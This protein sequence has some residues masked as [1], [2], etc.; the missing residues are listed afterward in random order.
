MRAVVVLFPLVPVTAITGGFR[1]HE[2]SSISLTMGISFSL[3]AAR[4]GMAGSTPGLRTITS[5]LRKVWEVCFPSSISIPRARIHPSVA[6]Q[7]PPGRKPWTRLTPS[8][9]APSI[10]AR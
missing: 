8:A 3:A 5:P 10:S 9:S 4:G 6:K 7:S 1:Y 2:A